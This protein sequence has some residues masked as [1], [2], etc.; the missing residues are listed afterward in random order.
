MGVA[1]NH[2]TQDKKKPDVMSGF[3]CGKAMRRQL[4]YLAAFLETATGAA[5]ASFAA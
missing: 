2:A 1:D 4:Y 3:S 5:A